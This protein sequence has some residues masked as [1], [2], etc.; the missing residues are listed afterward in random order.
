M[1][2]STP[3]I[4]TP[5]VE[6]ISKTNP[7]SVLD[8]GI[9]Q[10]KWGF[11]CREYLES[12]NDRVFPNQ[13]QVRIDGIEIFKD[14]VDYLPWIRQIYDEIYIGDASEI[15]FSSY[16]LI[17][18]CDVIEHLPK[19]KGLTLINKCKEKANKCFIVNIPIGENWLNNKIVARNLY[20]KHQ[21]IWN[22][23]DLEKFEIKRYDGARGQIALG[24]YRKNG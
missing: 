4:I 15:D 17:I 18:A 22:L 2:S 6:E 20:E 7:T 12:W 19:E 16:D 3:K 14:Y 13:W 5:I 23:G 11:L 8:I 9:G 21:S 1:P 24:V 10:G